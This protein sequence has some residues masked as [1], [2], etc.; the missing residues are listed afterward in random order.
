MC[1]LLFAFNLLIYGKYVCDMPVVL[2]SMLAWALILG[3]GREDHKGKGHLCF[4]TNILGLF[5]CIIEAY[6]KI[7]KNAHG[8]LKTNIREHY[9][10]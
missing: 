7:K 8:F 4:T 10:F 9:L 6:L 2:I 3:V 5:Q 1:T